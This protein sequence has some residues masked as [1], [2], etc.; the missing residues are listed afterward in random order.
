MRTHTI[1]IAH[2]NLTIY[3]KARRL[4]WVTAWTGEGV[5]CMTKGKA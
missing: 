4:G 5:I 1:R 2:R 3:L